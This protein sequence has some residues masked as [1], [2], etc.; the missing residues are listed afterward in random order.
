MGEIMKKTNLRLIIMS[1]LITVS[2]NAYSGGSGSNSDPYQIGN[3]EDLKELMATSSDWNKHF[4]QTADLD[5]SGETTGINPIGNESFRFTGDYDGQGHKISNLKLDLTSECVGLFGYVIGSN[6]S[7]LGMVA[8]AVKGE[9]FVG[10]LVGKSIQGSITNSYATGVVES[11]NYYAGGL[12]AYGKN[13]SITDSYATSSVIGT[14]YLGGLA[15][16]CVQVSITNSYATGTVS[17]DYNMGGLVGSSTQGSIEASYA[18]GDV[19][20]SKAF[21]GGLVGN[22]SSNITDSYAMGKVQGSSSVGGLVGKG[23]ECSIVHSYAMGEVLG[24]NPNKTGGLI[25]EN[26]GSSNINSCYWDQE[27]SGQ[28]SSAGGTGK[29]SAEMKDIATYTDWDFTNTWCI[30]ENDND[31]YPFLAWQNTNSIEEEFYPVTNAL[32]QNYPNPFNPGTVIKFDLTKDSK[33]EL[34]IY[35][36]KGQL[37]KKLVDGFYKAGHYQKNFNAKGLPAGIYICNLK[38]SEKNLQHKMILCK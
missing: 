37:V 28:S 30:S 26:S 8:V 24:E 23:G 13:C 5:L 25:G 7:N 4:I 17:G 19:L 9:C 38:T 1:F 29:S 22:N 21:V 31:G 36:T 2:L 33:V 3:L 11:I 6:I 20:A 18:T 32:I 16:K 34:N 14:D 12:V 27:T 10:G 15:G 35:N